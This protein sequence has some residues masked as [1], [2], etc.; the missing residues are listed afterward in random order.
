[1]PKETNNLRNIK[2]CLF[3]S[4]FVFFPTIFAFCQSQLPDEVT[5]ILK[6]NAPAVK[7]IPG[8]S[9]SLF[10]AESAIEVQSSGSDGEDRIS[11]DLK[12][13]DIIEL[14][15]ILSLKTGKTIVPSREIVGRISLYLNN[16]LFKDV[17]DIITVSQSLACDKRGDIIYVMSNGEYRK[18]YGKDYSEPRKMATIR[19]TYA[20][21]SNVFN[22]I[23]QLKS[24]I[25]KIVADEASGTI[26]LIDLPDK[27]ELL[28]ETAKELDKPMETVV[29]DLNYAKPADAKAQ[30]TAAMT[31]GIGEVIIDERSGKAIVSDLSGKMVKLKRI[32][33]ELDEESRQVFIEADIVQ[34]TLSD[35]YKRGIEWEKVFTE[36]NLRGLDFV[37]TF[38]VSPTLTTSQKISVGTIASD[39]FSIVF[40]MLNSYGDSEVLSQPRIAIVNNEEANIMIGSKD[41]FITGTVSQSQVTNVTSEQVE[42]VDVGIKL[43]VSPRINKDGFIT[44]KIKPEVSS[45]R[46]T[47]T[48]NQGSRIPIVQTAQ[49]ETSVKIKDGTTIMI[50]GLIELTDRE[51]TDGIP[52]ISKIPLIGHF[53]S[54]RHKE[55]KRTELVFFITPHLIR[56]DVAKKGAEAELFI[57]EKLKPEITKKKIVPGGLRQVN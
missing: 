24:D 3:I 34:V 51:T 25:G 45:V 15:R 43:K 56:G 27:L 36:S 32:V 48:T 4:L 16:V 18:M 49:A 11:L 52:G 47:L 21:P 39:K 26:F 19:L 54:T 6:K 40:N 44:M 28:Q 50:G 35:D 46:E 14:L 42:F 33:K 1:M 20:K 55:K 2:I 53:F 29:Y 10:D 5:S 23:S 41:A 13:I 57:P 22:A 12:S 38:P 37:G 30:L 9:S 17:L 7:N 31:P 8:K